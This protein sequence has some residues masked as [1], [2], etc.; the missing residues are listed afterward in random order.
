MSPSSDAISSPVITDE[1]VSIFSTG[2]AADVESD[3]VRG[4]SGDARAAGGPTKA[5]L[6]GPLRADARLLSEPS[7]RSTPGDTV[8][9]RPQLP[10]VPLPSLPRLP[11]DLSGHPATSRHEAAAPQ[12]GELPLS[13]GCQAVKP[14]RRAVGSPQLLPDAR[15]G[16]TA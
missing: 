16:H 14:L 5:T 15:V 6:P 10:T 8:A 2:D 3:F 4:S 11:L 9:L 7:P 13:R 1:P 12:A